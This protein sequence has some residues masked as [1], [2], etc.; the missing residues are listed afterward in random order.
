M[1][2]SVKIIAAVIDLTLYTSCSV[3]IITAVIDLKD[4]RGKLTTLYLV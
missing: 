3:I 4:H 2:C 1:S